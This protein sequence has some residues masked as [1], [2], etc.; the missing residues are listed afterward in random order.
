MV[1]N[2]EG[3]EPVQRIRTYEQVMAQIEERILDGR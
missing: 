1:T 2:G 3:W